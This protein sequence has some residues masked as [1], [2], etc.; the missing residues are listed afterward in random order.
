MTLELNEPKTPYSL[1]AV[2]PGESSLSNGYDQ[3]L[4][5]TLRH[6]RETHRNKFFPAIGK[7]W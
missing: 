5:L 2:R 4:T 1:R 3:P 7:S 6:P